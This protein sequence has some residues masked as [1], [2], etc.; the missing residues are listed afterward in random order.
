MSFRKHAAGRRQLLTA[1]T[2]LTMAACAVAFFAAGTPAHAQEQASASAQLQR[3]AAAIHADGVTGVLAEVDGGRLTARAGEA[4][5]G[6][7]VP[8]PVNSYVRIGSNTKTFVATVVLQLAAERRLSLSDTVGHWLPGV[9]AGHGND[10]GKITVRELLQHT[11]G[12][13]DYSADLPIDTAQEFYQH[14]YRSF[15]P[16][17]LVGLA[18]RHK[19][20]FKSGAS[21]SYSNT[22]YVLLGMIIK[23]ATGQDWATEVHDRIIVPLGLR[24][25]FVP[26]AWPYLP[27]PHAEGYQQYTPGGPLID[28]TVENY[29]WADAAGA[30]VS[31][32][33]DLSQFFRALIGGRLLPPAELAQMERTVPVQGEDRAIIARYGLGLAWEPLSCGGGYWTHGGDVDGVSTADGVTS[34][35]RHSVVVAAFTELAGLPAALK[36]HE[37]EQRLVDHALCAAERS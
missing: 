9:V 7:R 11:S 30:I 10:G 22:N 3:D 8:V 27:R 35:G 23:Q 37:T 6:T 12:L 4:L 28:T 34:D 14:Q 16:Q 19:P 2:G 13:Y 32:P 33:D 5:L 36:Q 31:T 1:G 24:H 17:Y 25:T 15:A 21:W 20:L 29:T 26:G 18:M